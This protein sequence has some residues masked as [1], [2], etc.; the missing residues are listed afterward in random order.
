VNLQR[1]Q[2]WWADLGEP[3]GSQ[4]G[5]RRPVLIIQDDHFNQ[6]RLATVII[7]SFTSNLKYRDQ[8]SCVYLAKQDS[9]LSKDSIINMTQLATIDKAW[10]ET[11][12]GELS[13]ENML[14]VD[15][16]LRFV[17]GL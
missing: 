7:L 12:V 3:Q 4:P 17:L 5:Y 9:G 16:A 14:Q 8:P 2:I 10:L 11:L 15:D 13:W 1:G 6:S